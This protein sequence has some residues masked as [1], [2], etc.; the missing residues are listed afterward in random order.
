MT[1][2]KKN[3]AFLSGLTVLA[4]FS[5]TCTA[6]I[7]LNG[8]R[9]IYP[10]KKKEVTVT[11]TNNNTTPVLIQNWI[12]NGNEKGEPGK[13]AVPFVLTPPINR[14]DPGKG[15]TLRI[16]YIGSTPLPVDKESVFWLNVLE[17]P[18]KQK[19]ESVAD[20][21]LNIAFRTRIKIFYRP[22]GLSGSPSVA[23]ENLH[24]SVQGGGVKVTNPS[25]YFVSLSN[26]TLQVN[27]KTIEERA[28][29]IA[30]GGSDTYQ[31][32]GANVSSLANVKYTAI[33]D[34]GGLKL[35]KAKN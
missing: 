19:N 29:M 35:Y 2:S 18:S 23:A 34:Y 22:E 17:I 10:A 32:K 30:P 16:S 33:N 1:L 3:I 14:V 6:S 28:R 21:K 13:T 11:V 5:N 9:V 25:N 8:T 24:W 7:I 15:Q 26:V 27:G 4:V 31:F 20:S 12:D